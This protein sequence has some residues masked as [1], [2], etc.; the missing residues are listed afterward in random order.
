IVLDPHL[1][2]DLLREGE[3]EAAVALVGVAGGFRGDALR[4]R[5]RDHARAERQDQQRIESTPGAERGRTE[6]YRRPENATHDTRT[7]QKLRGPRRGQSDGKPNETSL[8]RAYA[9][10]SR[11]AVPSG[12]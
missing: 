3:N 8:M 7:R 6:G 9:R 11:Q 5:G 12:R 4:V 10:K 2:L 1:G